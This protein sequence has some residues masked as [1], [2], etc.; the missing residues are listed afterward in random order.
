V[1]VGG[2]V[3]GLTTALALAECGQRVTVLEAGEPGMESSWA[4]GGIVS[5]VPPWRYPERINQLVARSRQLFPML[6]ERLNALSGV[7]IEYLYSGLLLTG[8]L[9]EQGRDWLSHSA[10]VVEWGQAGDFEPALAH[11]TETAALLPEVT[12]VRNS[13]LVRALVLA[14]RQLGVEVKRFKVA[15]LKV[16][17]AGRVQ[18]VVSVNGDQIDADQVVVAAGAWADQLLEAS[19][20]STIGLR[21][22][23]G[24]MLLFK[25]APGV[26]RHIVNTGEGYLIPRAD[27]HILVGSTVEEVGFDRRPSQAAHDQLLAFAQRQV[28]VLSAATLI[29]HWA[30]LRPGATRSLPVVGPS[31]EVEGLWLNLA[32]F[33]NGV[34]LAPACA[35][36]LVAMM[37]GQPAEPA[38]QLTPP[39]G[40]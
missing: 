14:L 26:L 34:G 38:L 10:V 28:P 5:P 18:G 2:G 11:S 29:C 22:V 37:D 33:R 21:P 9:P 12:Q 31:P 8:A 13:R 16:S 35:E 19:G 1:V 15:R 7:D 25:H 3:V 20:L 24:Q 4:G 23:R 6:A 17:Q 27:G 40:Q 30:G 36:L 32:H 39:A